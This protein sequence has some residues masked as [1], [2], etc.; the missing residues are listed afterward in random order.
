MRIAVLN[1]SLILALWAIAAQ[2]KVPENNIGNGTVIQT[3]R[4]NSTNTTVGASNN[5]IGA[6]TS[7]VKAFEPLETNIPKRA[8]TQRKKP[9]KKKPSKRF[10]FKKEKGRNKT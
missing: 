7:V 1:T 5:R 6:N 10:P 3:P 4:S 9:S 2:A 8:S